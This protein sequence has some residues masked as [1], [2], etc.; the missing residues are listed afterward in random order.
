MSTPTA[1]S[2]PTP[3]ATST[4]TARDGDGSHE[5]YPEYYSSVEPHDPADP[6]R[7]VYTD[8]DGSEID[9]EEAERRFHEYVN[10]IRKEHGLEPLAHD[11]T[12]ATVA[13]GHSWD[14]YDR[15]FFGHEN[16]DGEAP[17]DRYSAVGDD[18]R[19]FGENVHWHDVR[20]SMEDGGDSAEF[21]VESLMNSTEHRENILR[22]R[23]V[24]QSIGIVLTPD[25]RALVTQN[26]CGREWDGDR[27]A[28]RATPRSEPDE[29]P[30]DPVPVESLPWK[31]IWSVVDGAADAGEPVSEESLRS[32]L[33]TVVDAVASRRET[34]SY[35]D[36]AVDAGVLTRTGGSSLVLDDA[37]TPTATVT[38][39]APP[40][41]TATVTPRPT[42]QTES[43]GATPTRPATLVAETA[44]DAPGFG[45][46]GVVIA[47]FLAAAGRRNR[48]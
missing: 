11:E 40:T 17:F 44:E 22:E 39:S 9:S 23:W 46:V 47:L 28:G 13:R 19:S 8:D 37:P 16:P 24:V 38:P 10:E 3:T 7:T 6:G 12:I 26:F 33:V 31:E 36:R 42:T 15:E 5:R 43:T 4:P 35:L 34:V 21:A 2:T 45:V 27:S 29:E 18:C 1:T 25:G 48:R 14:M 20:S 41:R 30:S 32:A